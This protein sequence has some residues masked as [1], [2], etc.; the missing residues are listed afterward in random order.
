MLA[1]KVPNAGQEAGVGMVFVLLDAVG[2]TVDRMLEVMTIEEDIGD[3]GTW[4]HH[5]PG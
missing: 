5:G 2:I 1:G 4:K 3:L